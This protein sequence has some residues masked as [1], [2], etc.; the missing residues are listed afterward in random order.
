MASITILNNQ[1]APF[2]TLT[3]QTISR[4]IQVSDD[5]QRLQAAAANAAAGYG[6]TAGTEYEGNLFGVV[7][8]ATPGAQGAVY[9]Y[10]LN[11]IAT[12]LAT[13]T[14]AASGAI[15]QLDNGG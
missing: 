10:A 1:N 5:I 12:A 3:V 4:L 9:A 2:G 8:S 13:F 11:V 7:P 6:G 15:A 14:I